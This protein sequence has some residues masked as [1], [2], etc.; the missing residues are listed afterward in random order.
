MRIRQGTFSH[1]PD[2]D[3]DEIKAQ[4]QY[5]IDNDWAVSIEYTDDPHPRN[6]YWEMWGLPMFD[7]KDP[8]AAFSEVKR[9][10]EAFPHHYI[11]VNAYNAR[12]T[13]QTTALSFMVNRPDPEPGFTLD[14]TETNDRHLHYTMKAYAANQPH[15]ERYG[16]T[17]GKSY[18]R[19]SDSGN[20][21]AAD[22]GGGNGKGDSGNGKGDD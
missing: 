13:K 22:Q 15:G 5:A 14:R 10:R 9:C 7:T 4:I 18:G 16:S 1:L 6:V 12:Y 20:T 21:E 11:K 19:T 2:L 8:A 17:D 3:D